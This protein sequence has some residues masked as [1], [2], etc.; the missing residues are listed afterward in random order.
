MNPADLRTLCI[1]LGFTVVVVKGDDKQNDGARRALG[2]ANLI[3]N[4]CI[5]NLPPLG[6]AVNENEAAQL[7]DIIETLKNDLRGAG[8]ADLHK[9]RKTLFRLYDRLRQRYAAYADDDMVADRVLEL[10]DAELERGN[11]AL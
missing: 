3:E 11:G 9:D 1:A 10:L 6:E 8:H 2:F 5:Y 7:D 4:F